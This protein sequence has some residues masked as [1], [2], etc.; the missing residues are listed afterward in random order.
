MS[1]TNP[2]ELVAQALGVAAHPQARIVAMGQ[3]PAAQRSLFERMNLKVKILALSAVIIPAALIIHGMGASSPV[4]IDNPAAAQP[5]QTQNPAPQTSAPQPA[6]AGLLAGAAPVATVPALPVPDRFEAALPNQGKGMTSYQ[7]ATALMEVDEFAALATAVEDFKRKPY[8]DPGGL[9]VG[10]GYCVTKRLAEYGP[11][12]V[13]R[14]LAGAGFA[15]AQVEALI[16]NKKAEVQKIVVEPLHAVRLLEA[17][18]ED[19]RSLAEAAVGKSVFDKLPSNRQAALTHLAYNTGNVAQFTQL[20]S[21]TQKGNDGK[22]MLNMR[23]N[24][25]GSDG[26]IH[27]NHRQRAWEQAMHLGP[28]HFK[29]ALNDPNAFESQM[30]TPQAE[31]A[32]AEIAAA[33]QKPDGLRSKLLKRRLGNNTWA[34]NALEQENQKQSLSI[35]PL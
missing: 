33:A 16:K 25:R 26:E 29:R 30:A 5:M 8:Y 24:W 17:T 4:Q 31:S 27:A 28:D 14:D 15:P 32:L 12:R 19:Y 7:L 21:A 11:A 1:E 9:N 3:A 2:P 6:A 13:G 10:M 35:K 23:V 18:K 34:S 20:V 22:A